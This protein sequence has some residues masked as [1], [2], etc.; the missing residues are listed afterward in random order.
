MSDRCHIDIS[1]MYSRDSIQDDHVDKWM[2][3][4]VNRD[5]A[6][7][8]DYLYKKFRSVQEN[9][10][11]HTHD[12]CSP[13]L[14]QWMKDNKFPI[15]EDIADR[16]FGRNHEAFFWAIENGYKFNALMLDEMTLR[17]TLSGINDK[18][19]QKKLI[20]II[21]ENYIPEALLYL[22]YMHMT[23]EDTSI[24]HILREKG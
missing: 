14:L 12:R 3:E 15:S 19:V 24:L 11:I 8:I 16:C 17:M 23:V 9:I 1:D 5:H 6:H 4:A 13:K 20:E 7:I 10:E 18:D 2:T 21:C 22:I